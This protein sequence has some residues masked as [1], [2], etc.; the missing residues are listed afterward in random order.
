LSKSNVYCVVAE[1]SIND[2]TPG[3]MLWHAVECC[4]RCSLPIAVLAFS[5]LVGL[6]S[7]IISTTSL[8]SRTRL[9][10]VTLSIHTLETRSPADNTTFGAG[11][12]SVALSVN[13]QCVYSMHLDYTG[14]P[15]FH[16]GHIIQLF[17][18]VG[19]IFELPWTRLRLI[20]GW[21]P[22]LVRRTNARWYLP[23][24]LRTIVRRS[25]HWT[26]TRRFSVL[27]MPMILVRGTT[28]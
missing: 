6:V 7:A 2:I 11:L 15:I 16:T 14:L 1:V 28:R 18:L 12:T 5:Q 24:L 27:I 21:F 17:K 25:S 3:P 20:C 4:S 23:T 13:K 22:L 10:P 26:T 19:L 8:F 9:D